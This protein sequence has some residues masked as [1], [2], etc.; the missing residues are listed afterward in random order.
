[1][2]HRTIEAGAPAGVAGAGS[3]LLDLDPDRIL[4][5]VDTHLD[6]ALGGAGALAFAPERTARAA[7]IPSLTPLDRLP[8]CLRVHVGHHQQLPAGGVSG[9]AGDQ[10]VGVEFRSERAAFFGLVGREGWAEGNFVSQDTPRRGRSGGSVTLRRPPKR[11]AK[12]GGR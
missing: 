3:C 12:G 2:R 9:D 5:A 11:P 1:E 8:Q 6:D 4:V 7:E 10:A